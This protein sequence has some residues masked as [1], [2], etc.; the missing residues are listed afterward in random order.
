MSMTKKTNNCVLTIAVASGKGGVGKTNVVANLAIAMRK[1]GS[2]VL[3][4]DADL[5][6]S[7]IDVLLQLAPKHTIQHMLTGERSLRDVIVDGPHGIKILPAGSGVQELT[8]L[9]EFQRLKILEEFD[10]YPEAI[11]VVLIDTGAGISE[12]VAF[13]C[14]AA[15]ETVI[16]TTPEPTS[17][18]G[19]YA[20]MKVLSTRYQ[21]KA[22]RVLVNAVRDPREGFDVFTRLSRAAETFL[23]LSLDYLGSIPYDE[24][25]PRSVR[26][27][28]AFIDLYPDNSAACQIRDIASKLRGREDRIKGSLQFFLGS[29]VSTPKQVAVKRQP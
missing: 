3:I 5:G 9:N 12:N 29:L 19:A 15:Q 23:T 20:L 4:V 28:R 24:A 8:A 7:N 2:R 11:D 27:Q 21:E 1:Q 13:F 17:I 18:T 25:I 26:A 10:A 16:V 14:V 6:L 22:F